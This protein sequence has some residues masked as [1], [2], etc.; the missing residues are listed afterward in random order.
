MASAIDFA[1]A[2]IAIFPCDP[3]TKRPFTE[4]GFKNSS[5]DPAV[6]T[7]WWRRRPH[8]MVAIDVGGNNLLVVDCDLNAN[9]DGEIV[10]DGL[11]TLRSIAPS[12]PPAGAPVIVTPSGG[13][14]FYFK[15]DSRFGNTVRKLGQG[16]DTRGAGGYAIAAGKRPDGREYQGGDELIA[17]FKLRAIPPIPPWLSE[18]LNAPKEPPPAARPTFVPPTMWGG[19]EERYAFRTLEKLRG[20][21]ESIQPGTRN[22]SLNKAAFGLGQMAGAGWIPQTLVERVLLDAAARCGLSATEA[23]RTI[24]S[25]LN[26]G[27]RQ[28]RAPLGAR[29]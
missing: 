10:T 8:A 19:R 2:G 13:I 25:G 17:A 23:Q 7:A 9:A 15:N 16:I 14:H 5:D 22:E 11:A 6:V 26:A 4:N 29:R 21:I 20:Q 28:P 24:A 12:W 3:R 1:R 18:R 27:M